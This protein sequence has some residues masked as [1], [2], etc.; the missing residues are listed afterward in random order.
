MIKLPPTTK[1][2]PFEFSAKWLQEWHTKFERT[3]QTLAGNLNS[4]SLVY[5]RTIYFTGTFTAGQE[6]FAEVV[7][8]DM[9]FDVNFG[10]SQG[11][12]GIPAA[13]VT[14]V[15][16]VKNGSIQVGTITCNIGVSAPTYATT[17]SAQIKFSRGDTFSITAPNPVDASL[18]RTCWVISGIRF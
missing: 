10:L 11:R 7:S 6:V 8:D 5:N 18:A 13:S 14:S 9:Y 4:L 3:Y 16:I 17:G 1:F 2:S 12:A 15:F